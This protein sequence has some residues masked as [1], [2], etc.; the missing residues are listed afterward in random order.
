M[1]HCL[2]FF[3][4]FVCLVCL[5]A[6]KV[7]AGVGGS[8]DVN[9]VHADDKKPDRKNDRSENPPDL[10]P[11]QGERKN[12]LSAEQTQEFEDQIS[13]WNQE[14]ELDP[15]DISSFIDQ[16]MGNLPDDQQRDLLAGLLNKYPESAVNASWRRQVEARFKPLDKLVHTLGTDEEGDDVPAVRKADKQE[17]QRRLQGQLELSDEEARRLALIVFS[18]G[19]QKFLGGDH[20]PSKSS[21]QKLRVG[22]SQAFKP[23]ELQ[24]LQERLLRANPKEPA[25]RDL[26][27]NLLG[28]LKLIQTKG[29]PPTPEVSPGTLLPEPRNGNFATD[30]NRTHGGQADVGYAILENGGTLDLIGPPPF[31]DFEEGVPGVR[32]HPSPVSARWFQDA[33]GLPVKA[34][35][36]EK[37][38]V[39]AK[40]HGSRIDDTLPQVEGEISNLP[41]RPFPLFYEGGNALVVPKGKDG[42]PL[43]ITSDGYTQTNAL[44]QG[45]YP[46]HAEKLFRTQFAA[47]GRTVL[48]TSMPWDGTRHVDMN[49]SQPDQGKP[50]VFVSTYL[51]RHIDSLNSQDQRHTRASLSLLDDAARQLKPYVD[52]IRVPQAPPVTLNEGASPTHFSRLNALYFNNVA[53]EKV[54]IVPD[55]P[56]YPNLGLN[57]E[58]NNINRR[59]LE[60]LGYKKVIITP[61][62]TAE[63]HGSFHCMFPQV[64]Y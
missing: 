13:K 33:R 24:G 55:Y 26:K 11:E 47:D 8:S 25:V 19:A 36:G 56:K 41:V 49:I 23:E 62:Y 21:E 4:L 35:D 37:Y 30:S 53:G 44:V 39:D 60:D 5:S 59:A 54:A 42:N 58:I 29:A 10:R 28:G 6:G 57:T 48:K 20:Q 1:H 16:L 18:G 46:E 3:S 51:D 45:T 14:P 7:Q 40:Y 9:S 52:V 22:L 50:T 61:S 34:P 64:C 38:L 63:E 32:Y 15:A 2:K 12:P 27:D 17:L 43:V 31:R